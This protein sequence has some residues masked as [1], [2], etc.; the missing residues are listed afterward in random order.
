MK[1]SLFHLIFALLVVS[2]PV[3]AE[4]ATSSVDYMIDDDLF[5]TQ[6]DIDAYRKTEQFNN[7][8]NRALAAN[9]DELDA[10][11][12]QYIY[13]ETTDS[14]DV[15]IRN[16]LIGD[17]VVLA[18]AKAQGISVTEAQAVEFLDANMKMVSDVLANGTPDER[19]AAQQVMDAYHE[20]V[21]GF[22]MTESEYRKKIQIPGT[23]RLLTISEMKSRLKNTV[24]TEGSMSI[25]AFDTHWEEYVNDLRKKYPSIRHAD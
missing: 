5:I 8:K 15:E 4:G 2:L 19:E 1:W 14:T 21:R 7:T 13:K 18:E 23:I 6:A 11:A 12:R 16:I 25:E 9:D 22:G 24:D 17:L 20:F 3:Y 10:E